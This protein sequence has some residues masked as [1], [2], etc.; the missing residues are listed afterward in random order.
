MIEE[1]QDKEVIKI[2]AHP[3]SK[4]YLALTKDYEVYSWGNGDGGRLGE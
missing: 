1:L 4:H 3:E 2:A